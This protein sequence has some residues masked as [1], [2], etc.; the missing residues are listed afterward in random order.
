MLCKK[1]GK[2]VTKEIV[3][4]EKDI[5]INLEYKAYIHVEKDTDCY[6]EHINTGTFDAVT[7]EYQ[8]YAIDYALREYF[9]DGIVKEHTWLDVQQHD[10]GKGGCKCPDCVVQCKICQL[11]RRAIESE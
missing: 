5:D 7:P 9:K 10:L 6:C 3:P 4:A 2:F 11:R 1:C 8:M